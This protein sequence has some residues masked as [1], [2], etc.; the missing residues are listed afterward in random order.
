M[1]YTDRVVSALNQGFAEKVREELRHADTVTARGFNDCELGFDG[2]VR[3]RA[4]KLLDG[5]GQNGL[6]RI[7]LKDKATSRPP[8]SEVK[9]TVEPPQA[10][11]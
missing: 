10:T 7:P 5:F 4:L 6:I 8:A 9:D 1:P 2:P 3:M 11:H